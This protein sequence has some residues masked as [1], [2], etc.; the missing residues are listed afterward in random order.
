MKCPRVYSF[1]MTAGQSVRAL[2]WRMNL[3]DFF[4]FIA[5]RKLFKILKLRK[6]SFLSIFICILQVF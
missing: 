2:T 5:P 6:K 4:A 1:L 3:L